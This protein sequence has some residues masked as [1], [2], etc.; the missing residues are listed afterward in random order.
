MWDCSPMKTPMDTSV[1][2]VTYT[3]QEISQLECLKGTINYSLL[4]VRFSLM[5]EGYLDASLIINIEDHSSISGWV[6]LLR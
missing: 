1:K 6:F 2:L 5:I 4:Y 3:W